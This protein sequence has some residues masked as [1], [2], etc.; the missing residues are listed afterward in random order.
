MLGSGFR[1][2]VRYRRLN[3]SGHFKIET[4][5]IVYHRLRIFL[6]RSLFLGDRVFVFC[7]RFL[8]RS[9]RQYNISFNVKYKCSVQISAVFE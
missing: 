1:K 5:N 4:R 9:S 6:L 3:F 8:N 7:D 2:Q